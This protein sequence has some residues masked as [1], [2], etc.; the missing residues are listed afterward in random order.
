[1]LGILACFKCLKTEKD[2]RIINPFDRL[3]VGDEAV[4]D[5]DCPLLMLTQNLSFISPS[6]IQRPISIVHECSE[7]CTF[8]QSPTFTTIE[9]EAVDTNKIV[10]KH[11]W[12]NDVFCHNVYCMSN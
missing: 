9:C 2:M 5:L 12:N 8:H 4:H 3:I 6:A 11:D 1:M 10:L 7:T